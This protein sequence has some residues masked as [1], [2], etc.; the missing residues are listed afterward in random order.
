MTGGTLAWGIA[1]AVLCI[2]LGVI[3]GIPVGHWLERRRAA[4]DAEDAAWRQTDAE[5][6]GLADATPD[7][8]PLPVQPVTL[9]TGPGKHR[10]P[11]GPRHAELPAA[12]YLPAPEPNP[13][14]HLPVAARGTAPAGA[15]PWDGTMTLPAPVQSP[16]WET[17]PPEPQAEVLEPPTEVLE[18]TAAD[19][20]RPDALTDSAWTRNMAADMDRWIAEHIGATD[21]TL[22]QITGGA[23]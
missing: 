10:H 6:K 13:W 15:G 8:A 17:R 3:I 23:R 21:S 20:L 9:R 5:W 16:P 18:P 4:R 2:L 19:C 1:F 14:R 22:K 12:G 11:A 7:P